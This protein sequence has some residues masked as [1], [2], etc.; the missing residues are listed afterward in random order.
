[1]FDKEKV[2]L[3]ELLIK[4]HDKIDMRATFEGNMCRVHG[5]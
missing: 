4:N 5:L 1:M 2:A 3:F